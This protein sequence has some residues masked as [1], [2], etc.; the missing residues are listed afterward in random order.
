[1]PSLESSWRP[2]ASLRGTHVGVLSK[3]LLR[4]WLNPT[5]RTAPVCDLLQDLC[6]HMSPRSGTPCVA[7]LI[8]LFCFLEESFSSL[9]SPQLWDHTYSANI[10]SAQQMPKCSL[11]CEPFLSSYPV[12]IPSSKYT[13]K[14]SEKMQ[15]TNKWLP[16]SEPPT[17]H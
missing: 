12:R 15:L 13:T 17:N 16:E 5:P 14:D 9:S 7:A 6:H 3:Q 10:Q 2:E 4:P 8:K 11:V 1:M